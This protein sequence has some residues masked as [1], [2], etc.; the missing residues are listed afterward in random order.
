MNHFIPRTNRQK[1]I[2][3]YFKAPKNTASPV[4][5]VLLGMG[6]CG[7]SQ[8]TLEYCQQSQ[9]DKSHTAV[10]WIDAMSPTTVEGN[11]TALARELSKP[12]F[13]VKE[14]FLPLHIHDQDLPSFTSPGT[15]YSTTHLAFGT[16]NKNLN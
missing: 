15:R 8:L 9:D 12:H 16:M 7:K 2:R 11:L 1:E 14:Y 6:G 10:F 5:V 4:V 13:D 3:E